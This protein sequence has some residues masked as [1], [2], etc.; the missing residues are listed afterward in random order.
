M[1]PAFEHRSD[2][3]VPITVM[4]SPEDS[5]LYSLEAL[6]RA[7]TSSVRTDA[8]RRTRCLALDLR[9]AASS[10]I[11]DLDAL[12]E[13]PSTKSDYLRSERI[14]P[15]PSPSRR[16]PWLPAALVGLGLLTAGV[17][18]MGAATVLRPPPTIVVERGADPP[19]SL[20]A[21]HA[22]PESTQGDA[23]TR[24]RRRRRSRPEP[25]VSLGQT[26]ANEAIVP[27]AEREPAP[28]EAEA[29]PRPARRPR[30]RSAPSRADRPE[31][32]SPSRDTK[33]STP[34]AEC[35]LD[36]SRCDDAPQ[37][38]RSSERPSTPSPSLPDKLGTSQI[39]NSLARVKT[40]AQ[41]CSL[42]HDVPA[43]TRVRVKLSIEGP[44]GS[45][46]SATPHA[47]HD[48]PLG[49]CV[50]HALSRASFPEFSSPSMGVL[51]SVRM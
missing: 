45:V 27:E 20:S 19:P 50:A 41:A 16:P 4:T 13:H 17:L 28:D 3:L 21:R 14:P 48:G 31:P 11:V 15:R 7:E 47:P 37:A 23:T 40:D 30:K 32:T 18:G 26:S 51:Y 24:N 10:G 34:T 35:I 8:P 22:R 42:A 46:T 25:V 12:R 2:S 1:S 44:T 36:P 29:T 5:S 9:N 6:T 43:G 39:R 38:P 33:S 49:R